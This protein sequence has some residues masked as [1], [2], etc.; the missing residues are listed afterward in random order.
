[1]SSM[2]PE[3]T[4]EA[5]LD[6]QNLK[7]AFK[8]VVANKG[9]PGINGTTT[10]ELRQWFH[11]NPHLIS[12]SVAQGKYKPLPIKR[13]YIPKDNGDK[14]PLGIPTV[15]DCFVQ[16]AVAQ[17]LSDYYEMRFSDNSYGYRPNRGAHEAINKALR[18]LNEGYIYV[19]DLD[20]S[21]FFDTV[22]HSKLL[23]I[24]SRDIKDGRVISLIHKFLR[25]P[26]FEDGKV[27][28]KTTIG[29]PQG[30][31]IS[32]ILANILLNELD[33]LLDSRGIRFV[34][35]AD[36]MVIMAKSWKA[37]ERTLENVKDF[38]ENKLF[39]KVNEQK[40]K[41]GIASEKSQFLG[42]AF[43]KRVSKQRKEKNPK[44]TWFAT[45]HRKKK[46]KFQVKVRE[47]L[48]R[49]APGGIDAVKLKLERYLVGWAMY[50]GNAVPPTW[51]EQVDQWMRRRIR[52]IY[53]KQW[54]TPQNRYRQITNRW[55]KAPNIDKFAYSVNSYWRMAKTPVI[56]KALGNT[57]L[58]AEGW[59]TLEFSLTTEQKQNHKVQ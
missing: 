45:V 37:A 42:F 50:Y 2:Q 10:E 53:W 30:G 35:Y 41:I 32:P 43:T 25:A 58:W 48:D 4:L 16:Q 15:Q 36:D 1:M 11:A 9:A 33:Q 59:M 20:L 29:T 44:A 24:L 26:V 47:I 51:T 3:V 13:V 28:P 23:Q 38:L 40:T 7:A 54:K 14:R 18:Y 27:G 8:S 19:I 46:D 55:R 34:R 39:L 49:R 22:N 52:Q 12:T 17:V 56:H 31:C 21:K 57:T 5:I 6:K